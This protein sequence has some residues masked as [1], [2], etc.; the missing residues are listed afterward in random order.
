MHTIG[1]QIECMHVK[2]DIDK[3][4]GY[5]TVRNTSKINSKIN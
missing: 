4:K 3:V 1:I 2:K 5:G